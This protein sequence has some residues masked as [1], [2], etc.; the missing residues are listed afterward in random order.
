MI[1]ELRITFITHENAPPRQPISAWASQLRH[2][3]NSRKW[4]FL[5]AFYSLYSLSSDF[6]AKPRERLTFAILSPLFEVELFFLAVKFFGRK[7]SKS[8]HP[9]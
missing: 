8:T 2:D 4:K 7:T 5:L 1:K 6:T 9:G 3:L